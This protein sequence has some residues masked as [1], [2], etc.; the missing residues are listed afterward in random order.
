MLPQLKN[1]L[2]RKKSINLMPTKPKV[3]LSKILTEHL[4]QL[5]KVTA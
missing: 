5:F 2:K 4:H 1:W 3:P